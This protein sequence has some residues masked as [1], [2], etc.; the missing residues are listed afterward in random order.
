MKEFKSFDIYNRW[1]QHIFSTK[2]PG[3]GWDGTVNGQ[4][5]VTGTYVWMTEGIDF[6]GNIIQRKGTVVL[7][8]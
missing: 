8:R 1:G 6:S 5:Q 7:I 4:P 2:N 3:K